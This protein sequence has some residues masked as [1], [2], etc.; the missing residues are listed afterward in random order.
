MARAL[1]HRDGAGKRHLLINPHRKLTCR[2]GCFADMIRSEDMNF[3]APA[4][5]AGAL[6]DLGK[7]RSAFQEFLGPDG[8]RNSGLHT[9]RAV[10]GTA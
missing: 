10:L 5:W 3:R 6:H 7:N 2:A 4:Q 9:R 8:R 1:T